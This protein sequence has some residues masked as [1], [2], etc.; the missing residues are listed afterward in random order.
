MWKLNYDLNMNTV[1]LGVIKG[2]ETSLLGH[3]LLPL[4]KMDLFLNKQ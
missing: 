2:F 4:K 1:A 3:Q